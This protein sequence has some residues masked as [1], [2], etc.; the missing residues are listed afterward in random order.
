MTSGAVMVAAGGTAIVLGGLVA[1]A[2]GPMEWAKGSW[3]AA[4]LVLVVGVAQYAMGLMRRADRSPEGSGW[5][6]LAGWN[7]GSVLVIGGTLVGTPLLVDLGSVLLVV[8]LVIALRATLTGEPR[9]L[10]HAYR[11][12][13]LVLALSIPVGIL[14][15]HLRN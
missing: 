3:A 11:V 14:L 6:Q 2:T 1:A 8:A 5:A 15:S 9:V 12:M 4:Y 10:G 13:L 7:G